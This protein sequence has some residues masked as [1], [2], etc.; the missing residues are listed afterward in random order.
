ARTARSVRGNEGRDA[1]GDG[2]A[3]MAHGSNTGVGARTPNH[4]P[5]VAVSEHG[6]RFT[7]DR[8]ADQK[9]ELQSERT[10]FDE[11]ARAH[12]QVLVPADRDDCAVL[13][14][15]RIEAVFTDY[16]NTT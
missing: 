11:V 6:R 4:V 7:V 13:L 1:P 16:P 15:R 10:F 5:S 9:S 3:D 2:L 8:R 14:D 12:Q